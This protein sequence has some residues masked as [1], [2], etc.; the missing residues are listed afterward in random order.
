M[1]RRDIPKV[2][3][4]SAAGATLPAAVADEASA[5]TDLRKALQSHGT[6]RVPIGAY[7]LTSKLQTLIQNNISGD[8]R[9]DSVLRPSGFPDYVLEVGNG[10]P[11]PNAGKIERLRFYGAAGNLGCL[12]MNHLSHM[13][14]LEDLLFSGGPCPALVVENCW[15]SNYTDIDI[16]GHVT[17]GDDPAKTAAVIFR[18]ACNNIYCRG[19]RIEGAHSG[20]IY[21]D[22]GPIYVV[23]G[24]IDDGFGGPQTAAAITVAAG[25]H[26]VVEDFYLGGMRD[27]FQI[28]VAGTLKLGR[29]CLDG[30]TNKPA[31]YDHRAWRHLD[32]ESSPGFSAASIGPQIDVLDL[33][34]AEFRRTHPSVETETPAAVYSRIHPIRQVGNL[35]TVANGAVSGNS[36][37]IGTS[38]RAAHNDLYTNS[39]LVHNGDRG[40]RK[41]LRSFVD[42]KLLLEDTR[43]VALDGDWSVEYCENHYTPILHENVWLAPG[44]T[45]FAVVS[46]KVVIASAPK[47]VTSPADAAYGTTKFKISGEG[48][49]SGR[50]IAGLFLINNVTGEAYYIQYGVDQH[51][52]VGIIYDLRDALAVNDEFSIVAGHSKVEAARRPRLTQ[53]TVTSA[54]V[55]PDLSLGDE[56]EITATGAGPIAIG[57]P[58]NA[59]PPAARRITISLCNATGSALGKVTWGTAYKL[60]PWVS[61]AS[62]F[63]RSIDFRHNGNNWIEVA[64]TPADVPN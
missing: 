16:L 39:F 61:P 17:R 19:L 45:L 4:A 50:D 40:R 30:G 37:V 55:G 62:G 42:G 14:R 28:D 23:T 10:Q 2:L 18:Q 6:V 63:N 52:F 57:N 25:G 36:I 54:R 34:G 51:D 44:Q 29:V 9:H 5:A 46:S 49:A 15:D 33:G 21:I 20:G 58:I 43:P 64:R 60:A 31:I 53:M 3:L 11:G 38:L 59:T 1:R 22:G 12:H 24:K 41:I 35:R 48:V 13:W 27:Q 26:L 7:Q 56:F 47:Y 32:V 8:S